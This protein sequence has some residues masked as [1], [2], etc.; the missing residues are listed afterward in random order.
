MKMKILFIYL[1][2]GLISMQTFG[3]TQQN[4]DIVKKENQNLKAT[5]S[6]LRQDTAFLNKKIALCDVFNKPREFDLRSFSN[7][8]NVVV[9]SCKGDRG[10]QTVKIEFLISHSLTH[11]EVCI[12]I[13]TDDA[14]AENELGDTFVAKEGN[15]ANE[16]TTFGYTCTKVPTDVPTKINRF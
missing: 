13:G 1:V 2:A 4:C 11:Q 7:A 6:K 9:L 8:F 16:S 10:Q 15:I 14:K 5:I 3:Q 12:N